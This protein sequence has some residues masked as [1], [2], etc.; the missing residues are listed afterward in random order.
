MADSKLERFI[1][2]LSDPNIPEDKQ[3]FI[4][5][6]DETC[7]HGGDNLKGNCTNR[8]TTACGGTN[9]KCTNYGV[10]GTSTNKKVCENKPQTEVGPVAPNPVFP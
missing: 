4:L 2:H 7:L 1:S 10:C 5:T 6:T 9:D 3:S 8:E